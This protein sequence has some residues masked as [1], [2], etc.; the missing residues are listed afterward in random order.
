[1]TS[2]RLFGVSFAAFVAIVVADQLSKWW[3]VDNL[4][5]H[6]AYPL[7]GDWF[8]FYL[9]RNPGAAF[10][11]GVDSTIIFSI[12]QIIATIVCLVALTKVRS[13]WAATPAVLIG[14]G[15]A[16][17][18]MDR[19]FRAP[20]GLHGHVV[21]FVSVGN[22]AIFNVADSAITVGVAFYV[23]FVLFLDRDADSSSSESG[24]SESADYTDQRSDRARGGVH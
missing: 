13:A 17:N 11:L 22:F 2:H 16:G 15:A 21:D 6:R 9:I 8:R 12:L 14:A 19:I 3:V 18:L 10:S 20:G 4:E 7:I 24:G 5:P 1:M 23:M